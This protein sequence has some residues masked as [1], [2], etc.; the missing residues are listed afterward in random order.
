MTSFKISDIILMSLT[1]S[2]Y[3]YFKRLNNKIVYLPLEIISIVFVAPGSLCIEHL[4]LTNTSKPTF[5]HVPKRREGV[6][7][8]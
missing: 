2:F 5:S 6:T 4:I 8:M 3:I 1:L 7:G